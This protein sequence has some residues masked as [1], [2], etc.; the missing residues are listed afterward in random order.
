MFYRGTIAD[1]IRDN[2]QYQIKIE[3]KYCKIIHFSNCRPF[4]GGQKTCQGRPNTATAMDQI[5]VAWIVIAIVFMVGIIYLILL[6]FRRKGLPEKKMGNGKRRKRP[7][8]NV[9]S[10]GNNEAGALGSNHD[11]HVSGKSAC[12]HCGNEQKE[13]SKNEGPKE[14]MVKG[15]TEIPASAQTT[16]NKDGIKISNLGGITILEMGSGAMSPNQPTFG[17]NQPADISSPNMVQPSSLSHSTLTD[18][19]AHVHQAPS[20]RQST[21]PILAAHVQESPHVSQPMSTYPPA[22]V[23]LP[24]SVSQPTPTYPPASVEPPPS[25]SL[26]TPT[27]PPANVQPPP[28]VSQSMP[29]YP[30]A[31]VQLPTSVSLPAGSQ[32]AFDNQVPTTLEDVAQTH[33]YSPT[34][35]PIYSTTLPSFSSDVDSNNGQDYQESHANP[36]GGPQ[37]YSS[38]AGNSQTAPVHA[39]SANGPPPGFFGN[40]R[41]GNPKP[42]KGKKSKRLDRGGPRPGN[43]TIRDHDPN[44]DATM[45]FDDE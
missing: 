17:R 28:S 5:Y 12:E 14:I 13:P 7:V 32:E 35:D 37:I 21:S 11:K 38:P 10:T 1:G 45:V 31:N 16:V 24:T 2:Y 15:Q 6:C 44:A 43:L 39:N 20:V 9:V 3:D 8:A 33:T 26:T 27:Y 23:Q 29:T 18:P 4:L 22:N 41:A 30:P 25:V 19:P 36:D 42:R 40:V 34:S